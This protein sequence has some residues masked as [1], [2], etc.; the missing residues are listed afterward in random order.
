MTAGCPEIVGA[1]WS[2]LTGTVLAI[3]VALQALALCLLWWSWHW[4]AVAVAG[5]LAGYAGM[6]ALG[7]CAG[8]RFWAWLAGQE[9]SRNNASLRPPAPAVVFAIAVL[10]GMSSGDD[11]RWALVMGIVLPLAV[12]PTAG[13]SAGFWLA[14]VA[15][16]RRTD[17]Q[18]ALGAVRRRHREARRAEWDA[19]MAV[20][21]C[22]E[23]S[24]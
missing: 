6:V 24:E 11:L 13:L 3:L 2:V 14:A 16:G 15:F 21:S 20:F 17:F 12:L 10:C 1:G 19:A 4:G 22:R 5:V 7:Y 8:R 23:A 18:G 9:W